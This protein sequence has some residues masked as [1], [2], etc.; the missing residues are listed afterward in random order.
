M[1]EIISNYSF[2]I[3]I[4]AAITIIIFIVFMSRQQTRLIHKIYFGI[5]GVLGIWIFGVIAIKLTDESN[6]FMLWFWDAVTNIGSAFAPFLA[7]F[8]AFAFSR[9]WERIPKKYLALFLLPLGSVILVWTNP[10]HHLFYRQFS[11][12]ITDIEFGPLMFVNGL[13]IFGCLG[14][15]IFIMIRF[16][17]RSKNA[18]YIK[19]ALLFSVGNMFPI[20]VNLL[21]T[22]GI[23]NLSIAATPISF[24]GT[25]ICHGLAIYHLHFLDIKPIAMNQVLNQISDCYLITAV[26]GLIIGYNEPFTTTIGKQHGIE[27]NKK[28]S[29]CLKDEDV[30]YKTGIY[31]LLTSIESCR[32]TCSTI[33]YEQAISYQEE[34]EWQ[35]LYYIV[36]VNPLIVEGAISGFVAI[37]K[38]V[39]RLRESMQKLQDSQ[40]RLVENERLA[41]LGQM[42][43]GLAH[44]LKT[45]IMSIAGNC[46]ALNNLVEECALSINDEEVTEED[47]TEIYGDMRG[48]LQKIRDACSYMSDIITAVKGQAGGMDKSDM[49]DFSIEDLMKRVSLLLRHELLSGHCKLLTEVNIP[50]AGDTDVLLHGDI[51]SLVQVINN[52]ISNAIYAQVDDGR[53]DI[54]VSVDI[55]KDH[56]KLSVIDWGTGIN[57]EV[58]EKLFRQMITSKGNQGTGLGIYISASVIKGK[59]GGTMAVEDNPEGGSVFIIKIPME[60]VTILQNYGI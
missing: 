18:L 57:E 37:F 51:N 52:L 11:I 30:E 58:K 13:M 9:G 22:T 41:S 28:L 14:I 46:A 43:G 39:S 25:F 44:N 20:I 10:F 21:A 7:L 17:L 40:L 29:D 60:N 32:T 33:N 5:A 38:D 31:N 56:L 48:W 2:A 50:S 34:G 49:A 47:Y 24:V 26:D 54:L 35:K 15:S 27:I 1:A 59:F 16:A 53:H 55:D 36:E 12:H 45:P 42:V 6:T 23:L 8:L 4:V 19:Q 3:L